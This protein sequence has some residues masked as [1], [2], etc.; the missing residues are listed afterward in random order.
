MR[1]WRMRIGISFKLSSSD[2]ERLDA[3]V[4]DRNAQ[5]DTRVVSWYYDDPN[6]D[7]LGCDWHPSAH[8]DQIISGLLNQFIAGLP[9]TW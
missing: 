2:R 7:R 6:L 1:V 8:D 9:L 3:I 5:G 4:A